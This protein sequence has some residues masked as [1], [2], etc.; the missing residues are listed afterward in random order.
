MAPV[1]T[2]ELGTASDAVAVERLFQPAGGATLEQRVLELWDSLQRDGVADCPVCGGE[3]R[4]SG[5][6]TCGS[7]LT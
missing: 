2:P 5:C 4:T 6:A 1:A 7:E 3:L